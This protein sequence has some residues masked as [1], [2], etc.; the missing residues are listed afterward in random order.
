MVD[1]DYPITPLEASAPRPPQVLLTVDVED[2]FHVE[3]FS[4][5]AARENW[6]EYPSRVEQNTESLL[7]LFEGLGVRATFFVLGWVAERCPGLVRRIHATGHEVACHSYWH[8]R[9]NNL[10]PNEFRHDTRQAKDV[11]ED[12]IGGPVRGYRAPT[13]SV[14]H[15]SL[16]ALEILSELG[17]KYD[18]SIYPVRHDVYGIPGWPLSP[19]RVHLGPASI[20]EVP[21]PTVDVLGQGLPYGGG[22]YLRILPLAY[23]EWALDRVIKTRPGLIYIHPWEIDPNQPRIGAPLKS[24]L[25]HYTGLGKLRNK[26][27]RLISRYPCAPVWNYIDDGLNDTGRPQTE[28]GLLHVDSIT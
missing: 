12:L 7:E 4:Q 14:V 22:G 21:A 18:S 8:R 17:F 13:F 24:K 20:I 25:R 23:H 10:T 27:E 28:M 9:V 3:A 6:E 2:Y 5:I 26:L 11:L 19:A 16:W 1:F 15:S